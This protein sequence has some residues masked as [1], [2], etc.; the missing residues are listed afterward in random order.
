MF[1]LSSKKKSFPTEL[2]EINIGKN[3]Q[4]KKNKKPAKKVFLITVTDPS[5]LFKKYLNRLTTLKVSFY[6]CGN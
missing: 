4:I 5:Y 2:I 1:D 6:S 3:I